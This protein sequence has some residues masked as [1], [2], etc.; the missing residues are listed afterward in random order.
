MKKLTRTYVAVCVVT[1]HVIALLLIANA[2]ALYINQN[3]DKLEERNPSTYRILQEQP[4]LLELFYPGFT[5]EQMRDLL[6]EMCDLTPQYELFTQFR[7]R[8][9]RGDY[10]NV[11]EAGY[12]HVED[13]GPWPPDDENFNVFVF[14]GSTAFGYG[15]PDD[16][17]IPSCLQRAMRAERF[18]DKTVCVYNWGRRAYYSSQER[19]LFVKLALHG[20]VPDIA[21]FVD[22]LNDFASTA[23]ERM[24]EG[25]VRSLMSSY[26]TDDDFVSS[27]LLRNL[28]LAK[29]LANRTI[30]D[31]GAALASPEV[32][33]LSPD[34]VVR[35]YLENKKMITALCAVY[36]VRPLFVWQPVQHY[37][38]YPPLGLRQVVDP[39]DFGKRAYVAMRTLHEQ[40]E[41]G[42]DFLWL[43]DLQAQPALREQFLYVDA[44]HYSG[45]FCKAIAGEILRALR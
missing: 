3:R 35:R 8:E 7:E 5:T 12:R 24:Y 9:Q 32:P 20:A 38:Y 23:G 1:V 41:V 25:T 43:A 31:A 2:V 21:I 6:A 36:G 10:V 4:Q 39:A 45:V 28:P 13:Q 34:Y 22:G 27:D 11:D 17:A 29:L 18:S 33:D 15:V 19:A 14:G 37:E 44:F 30:N 26:T 42:G 40:G 16:Q